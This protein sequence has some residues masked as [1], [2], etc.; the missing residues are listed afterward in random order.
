MDNEDF[1]IGVNYFGDSPC[2]FFTEKDHS[3]G[4]ILQN[5]ASLLAPSSMT[6]AA[7]VA[8]IVGNCPSDCN[9]LCLLDEPPITTSAPT[10]SPPTVAPTKACDQITFEAEDT[11][12]EAG[13]GIVF[14]F[15]SGLPEVQVISN[16]AETTCLEPGCYSIAVAPFGD[17]T[18]S[19]VDGV[20]WRIKDV[21]T[22][23]VLKA[24]EVS[25]MQ[26]IEANARQSR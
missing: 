5:Y 15:K 10:S 1:V 8:S 14:A 19:V 2:D 23:M 3:C 22:G 4:Y 20:S 24:R 9:P 6:E 13:D 25:G 11:I 26:R 16:T 18:D 7:W 21:G 12:G 17:D